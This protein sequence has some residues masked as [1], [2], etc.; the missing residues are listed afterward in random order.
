MQSTLTRRERQ[1]TRFISAPPCPPMSLSHWQRRS[2]AT[3]GWTVA[4]FIL[5]QVGFRVGIDYGLPE[6]R[7]PVFEIRARPLERRIAQV[8]EARLP[9]QP[10]TVLMMGSSITESAFKG[11]FLEDL[12][13]KELERPA[14]VFN[15]GRPGG[16]P[17]CSLVWTRRLFDRGIRPSLL[18]IEISPYL[19]KSA[20]TPV[21]VRL[22]P[23]SFLE[24]ND[25]PV[26]QR[27]SLD[28][29][30]E[31]KWWEVRL[32]PSYGHRLTMLSFLV[33]DLVPL[34]DR[35]P[36]G[37]TH[38]GR[39]WRAPMPDLAEPHRQKVETMVKILE[40]IFNQFTAGQTSVQALEELLDLVKKE[41]VPAALVL[42]PKCTVLRRLY[43]PENLRQ[44][45]ATVSSL[46]QQHDFPF[47]D[48][49][50]WLTDDMFSD[51]FHFNTEGADVFSKRL[52]AEVLVP[53]LTRYFTNT[54]Q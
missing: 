30:I 41:K 48:A 9:R 3:L 4:A 53:R 31:R 51:G 12:L 28:K 47:I 11:Q 43:H 44:F 27:Y 6:L 19:F 29:E 15:M 39:F 2:R 45:I 21:D 10:A 18:L 50:D 26:M 34:T 13:S 33:Q 42:T 5:L 38:D 25:V 24:K 16:G 40:P 7:D 49:F 17:M 1:T 35:V 54:S 32:L 8:R 14:V 36:V 52:A 20:D 46:S 22:F 37:G 23:V